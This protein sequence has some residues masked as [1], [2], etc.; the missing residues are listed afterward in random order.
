MF[1]R[2]DR[3]VAAVGE[4]KRRDALGEALIDLIDIRHAA[5]EHD[6]VGIDEVDGG[7]KRA[8]EPVA[9]S[10]QRLRRRG[11]ACASGGDDVGSGRKRFVR[12]RVTSRETRT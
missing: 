9:I 12:R 5:T 6:G 11:F 2:H 7:R 3:R 10:L 8:G 1:R 4:H